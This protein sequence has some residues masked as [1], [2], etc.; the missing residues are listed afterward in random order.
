M[1]LIASKNMR[2][3]NQMTL[4]GV[5]PS[6]FIPSQVHG[7]MAPITPPT[8]GAQTLEPFPIPNPIPATSTSGSCWWWPW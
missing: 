2:Y 3:G 1:I 4:H 5:A 7:Y 6:H 8:V